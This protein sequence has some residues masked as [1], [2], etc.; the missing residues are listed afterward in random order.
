MQ[1]GDLVKVNKRCDAGALWHKIGV[2]IGR[3]RLGA[4]GEEVVRV[5][6]DGRERLLD[7]CALD[8]INA[9]R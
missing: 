7:E 2:V 4:L 9:S 5:L 3:D 6:L 1:V 8:M